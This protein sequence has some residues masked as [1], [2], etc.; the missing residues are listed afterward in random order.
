MHIGIIGTGTIGGMLARAFAQADA[1]NHIWVYNRT[2]EK[3]LQVCASAPNIRACESAQ[4]V[5]NQSPWVFLC[6]KATDGQALWDTLADS[7][8]SQ[9]TLLCTC[10]SI[11]LNAWS[12]HTAAT[13]TKVIPSLT[14]SVRAGVVLLELPMGIVAKR[15]A[16]ILSLLATIATPVPVAAQQLRVSSDLTSCGPA[17]IASLLQSWAQSAATTQALSQAQ[18]EHLLTQT[19]LGTARLLEQGS[20]LQD[21]VAQISVPGGVTEAGLQ[22]LRQSSGPLFAAMHQATAAHLRDRQSNPPDT[23]T[24]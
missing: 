16:A 12:R 7:L 14:Q 5:V 3:A 24:P 17:F 11:D 9:H 10:S 13:I 8:T 18:A 20:T 6:T 4:A 19:L 22:V 2:P 21:I 23:P 15:Q 1:R